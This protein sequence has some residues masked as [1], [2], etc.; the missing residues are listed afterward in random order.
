ME[1]ILFSMFNGQLEL[2]LED[3]HASVVKGQTA[4]LLLG[5]SA[6]G[7]IGKIEIDNLQQAI[8]ITYPTVTMGWDR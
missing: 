2:E 7:R 3:V 8:R 1:S 5:Q 4:P 6:L